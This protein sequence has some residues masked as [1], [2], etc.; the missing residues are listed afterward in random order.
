MADGEAPDS[1]IYEEIEAKFRVT[2]GA[3]AE[4][5][6]A[7]STIAERY[8][9]SPISNVVNVDTY[10]DAPDLRLLRKGQTLRVRSAGDVVLMTAKSIGL[11]TPKGL[12]TRSEIERPAPNVAPDAPHLRAHDLPEELLAGVG[13]FLDDDARLRPLVR[14]HQAR[15]KRTVYSADDS[16][17]P[18]AEFSLDDVV[19][20]RDMGVHARQDETP[21]RW[22][23]VSHFTTLEVELAP[24]AERDKLREIALWLRAWPGLAADDLNKLQQALLALRD[25]AA[26]AENAEP[27]HRQHMAELCRRVWDEQLLVMLVNEAGVRYSDD[28]EYVHDMRVATRRARAAGRLYAGY[29]DPRSK[30]IERFM[31]RLRT[32]G[33]LLGAVRDLDVALQKFESFAGED[34]SEKPGAQA[35]VEKWERNREQAH[36]KLVEWLDSKEY[37]RFVTSFLRFCATPGAGVARFAPVPGEPPTPHQARHVLPSIILSRYEAIR[38]F[39]VLFEHAAATGEQVPIATLHAL[40]IEC[41]Y[42]RYHLE[43]SAALL[44]PESAGLIGSLKGLQEHLGDLNDASVSSVLVANA[45][46]QA[47]GDEIADYA[48]LQSATQDALRH[49]LPAD[50]DAF[51]SPETRRS[52]ALALAHI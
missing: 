49:S 21:D 17:A 44:G 32:T 39:E 52:L 12:H 10:Y 43:F 25:E 23:P 35:L 31:R 27:D 14:L 11:H 51:L 37:R 47:E 5:L 20:L 42:M 40:R 30:K 36:A 16:G 45:A 1:P 15:A 9:L 38:A 41:K 2:D 4:A 7:M 13:D 18:L 8:P 33:R 50:L 3:Q 34:G 29:F 48:A 26:D 46:V 19:V 24:G 28:I 6:R 22:R